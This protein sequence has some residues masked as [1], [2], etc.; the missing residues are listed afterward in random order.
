MQTGVFTNIIGFT[1]MKRTQLENKLKELKA[2]LSGARKHYGT[3][4]LVGIGRAV[5]AD[6][7]QQISKLEKE[8]RELN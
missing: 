6:L 2:A 5:Q 8:L 3:S 7:G 4:F 1:N